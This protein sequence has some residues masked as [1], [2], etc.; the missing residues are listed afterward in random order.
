MLV[1]GH[2]LPARIR[3]VILRGEATKNL[4]SVVQERKEHVQASRRGGGPARC[5]RSAYRKVAARSFVASLLRM[6]TM[7]VLTGGLGSIRIEPGGPSDAF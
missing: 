5:A 2:H 4:V 3:N 7:P 1:M 6:T